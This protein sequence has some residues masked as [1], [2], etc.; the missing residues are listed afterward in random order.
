MGETLRRGLLALRQNK[1]RRWAACGAAAVFC[2][3]FTPAMLRGTDLLALTNSVLMPGLAAAYAALFNFVLLRGRLALLKTTLPPAVLF[4]AGMVLGARI[5]TAG[6]IRFG[7]PLLWL[8]L[9][10]GALV[11]GAALYG[12]W[13]G[14]DS[15]A[16]AAGGPA[17]ALAAPK[18]PKKYSWLLWWAIILA[19]WVP[20]WLAA[21]PGY[22]CYDAFWQFTQY[23][24]GNITSHHP[25]LHTFVLGFM[26]EHLKNLTGSYNGGVALTLLLQMGAISGVMARGLKALAE[27]G[28]PRWLRVGGLLYYALHPFIAMLAGCSTKDAAFSTVVLLFVQLLV[29]AGR[30]L[31]GFFAHKG[32][33]ALLCVVAFLM[34]ALRNNAPYAWA[35]LLVFVPIAVKKPWRLRATALAAGVLAA[36][37]LYAGPLLGALG[38]EKG[39]PKEMLGVP[40]QQLARTWRDN[41][42]SFSQEDLA[43]LYAAVPPEGLEHYSPKLADMIKDELDTA[44]V[45][46][47]PGA[48]LGLWLRTGLKNPG[49]YIKSFLH[50]TVDLWYPDAIVNGY[51]IPG[52]TIANYAVGGSCYFLSGVDAPA[53]F[54]GK[55]PWLLEFYQT[56]SWKI[57]FQRIPVLSMLSSLGFLSW[58]LVTAFFY[59]LHRRLRALYLP[60]GFLLLLVGTV[61]L[62]HIMLPRFVLYLFFCFPLLLAVLFSPG[63]FETLTLEGE[64]AMRVL[65]AAQMKAAEAA[66]VEK[67]T[68]YR[69][70]MENAG[71]RAAEAIE[72]LAGA[73]GLEH[74]LL[75]LCGKGNNAGDAFVVARLLAQKGWRAQLLLLY[76]EG[77]SQLA[78]LNLDGLPEGAERLARA[79][80]AGWDAPIIVDGVFG[81]GFHGQLPDFVAEAFKRAAAGLRVALDVPSGLDCDT[82]AAA[83]H[84]FA[85]AHTLTFGAYKPAL[86]GNA[87]ARLAGQVHLLDIGL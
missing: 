33:V 17:P 13:L 65:T 64:G 51:N 85:A 55:I 8:A 10:A 46:E 19:C 22:F 41:P 15:R 20:C 47:Q 57:S 43:L 16:G 50:N 67:G 60:L 70:L 21:F 69:Q 5:D 37:C 31:A 23:I 76:D 61:L 53:T 66:A 18:A 6:D 39:D 74:R 48:Y 78:R 12:L 62:G 56:L 29:A 75:L 68:S 52:Y 28:V 2:A 26:V 82:G 45:M 4:S 3:G 86:V 72:Q 35:V 27:A 80:D 87:A 1:N 79:G 54:E 24:T 44:P 73:G 9:L 36:Y 59:A 11:F 38:V 77:F 14:L 40:M 58:A 49:I 81:T 63:S 71:T 25:P 83:P 34:L 30:N 42:G 7:S 32:R 84:T